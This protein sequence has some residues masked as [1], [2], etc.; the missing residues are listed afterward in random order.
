VL[1]KRERSVESVRKE[2]GVE[3]LE[4]LGRDIYFVEQFA[5]E[6][7]DPKSFK[8]LVQQKIPLTNPGFLIL[9]FSF[10]CILL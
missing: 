3:W 9:G 7:Q 1:E 6:F 8:N 5:S 2:S 10:C 4:K